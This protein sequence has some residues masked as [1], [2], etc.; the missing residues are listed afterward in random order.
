MA[1]TTE[2]H[3]GYIKVVKLDRGFGFLA[4][5]DQPDV[6]FNVQDVDESL[7]WDESLQERRVQ[8]RIVGTAKGLK[9]MDIRPAD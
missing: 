3:T 2:T 9:A 6:F 5:P 4:S 1:T 8:F 7:D